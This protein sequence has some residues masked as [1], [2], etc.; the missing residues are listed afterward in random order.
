MPRRGSYWDDT[1]VDTL[2]PTNTQD[3]V[4]L[5]ATPGGQSEGFTLVR[6]I[7]HLALFKDGAPGANGGQQVSLGI[8]LATKEARLAETVPDPNTNTDQPMGDWVWR[9][10]CAVLQDTG[11]TMQP[12]MCVG[13]YR[14]ARKMASGELYLVINN[15]GVYGTSMSVRCLGLV[16]CLLLRP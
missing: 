9:E 10:I 13:D 1:I 16:R 14:S 7:V 15:E 4:L 6:T 12:V 8:G 5:S 11:V 2:V 3:V